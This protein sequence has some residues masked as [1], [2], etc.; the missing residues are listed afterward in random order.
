MPKVPK[1]RKVKSGKERTGKG[2]LADPDHRRQRMRTQMIDG[3]SQSDVTAQDL[4]Q[5]SRAPK[6]RKTE[7]G[8]CQKVCQDG[9]K[10]QGPGTT[11][12]AFWVS[13]FVP[14]LT[15]RGWNTATKPLPRNWP[16]REIA[17][18]ELQATLGREGIRLIRMTQGVS[19]G[20]D[21][22]VGSSSQSSVTQTNEDKDEMEDVVGGEEN[23]EDEEE[24]VRDDDDQEEVEEDGEKED[25]VL[26]EGEEEGEEEEEES[27][28]VRELLS[29]H[30]AWLGL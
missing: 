2:N 15:S 5:L 13:K 16:G 14:A 8:H 21:E 6:R 10:L 1:K 23:V 9:A 28:V 19:S 17:Y 29:K 25:E 18:T 22:Q 11:A 20:S 12:V 7:V 24:V 26:E 3:N 30:S 27:D 4:E